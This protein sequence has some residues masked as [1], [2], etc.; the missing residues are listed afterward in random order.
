MDEDIIPKPGASLVVNPSMPPFTIGTD[1]K[2]RVTCI[3]FFQSKDVLF[4][5]LAQKN[6]RWSR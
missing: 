6:D 1:G 2:F 3:E 4:D 5:L